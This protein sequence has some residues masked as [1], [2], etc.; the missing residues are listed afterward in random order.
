MK[1]KPGE[2]TLK[3]F[4]R[5]R[6]TFLRFS[7]NQ[8]PVGRSTIRTRFLYSVNNKAVLKT[9]FKVG[10]NELFLTCAVE[11]ATKIEEVA[12]FAKETVI[13]Q[14]PVPHLVNEVPNSSAK[15]TY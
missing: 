13:G 5:I 10:A 1:R 11:I 12:K 7:F 3:L 9:L 15:P 2:S 14:R 6:Q 8:S 4:S